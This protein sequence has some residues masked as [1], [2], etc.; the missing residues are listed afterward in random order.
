MN[1]LMSAFVETIDHV[2]QEIPSISIFDACEFSNSSWHRQI[3]YST[4]DA[5]TS[6]W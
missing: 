5:A 4:G 1:V 6:A 2:E 3:C